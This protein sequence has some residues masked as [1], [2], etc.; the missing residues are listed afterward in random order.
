MAPGLYGAD[1]EQLRALSKTMGQSGSRLKT[2]ESTVNSLVQSAAWKGADGDRFRSEWT[3]SLRPMLS[4]TSESLESQ[5]QLLLK[6][7]DEQD[8]ASNS[9]S[10][11][12]SSP[13][14]SGAGDPG[15]GSGDSGNGSGPGRNW[16]DAFTD[17]NYE[18]A[19]GGIEWLLEKLGLSDGGKA[20]D[21]TAALMFVA[22]KFNWNLELAQVQSGVSKFFDFMK[23]AGKVLGV[24]GG[25]IGVLD[26]ISGI[27]GKDPFRIADGVIGG[28][29]S[30]AALVATG[31]IVGAP[32]GLV[33]GGAALGWGLLGMI[34]GDVPVT[35]RIWDFGA[36]VVG[37]VKDVASGVSDAVGWVGGKLGFG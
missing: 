29:L 20:S 13:T 28:G 10:G 3:S 16:G 36:G 9:G 22:D 24:L 5:S 12:A 2:V 8:Q 15:N 23:G 7:A 37:G 6:H 11:A 18:H 33:L 34:S 26:V 4:K 1:I 14:P 27:E 17:P 19:P 32:A 31:T 35:K 30:V 21:I 25:A